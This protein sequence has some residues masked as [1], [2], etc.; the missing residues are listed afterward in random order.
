[1]KSNLSFFK[2]FINCAMV[3]YL[4]N[5]CLSKGKKISPMFS[6]KFFIILDFWSM[7]H[8]MLILANGKDMY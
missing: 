8:S 5:L 6:S 3:L 7:T 1:M 2:L 4:R